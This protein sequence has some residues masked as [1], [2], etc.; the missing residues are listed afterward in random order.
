M[1]FVFMYFFLLRNKI[2]QEE[3]LDLLFLCIHRKNNHF[4]INTHLLALH[5]QQ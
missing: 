1:E 5:K 3:K 4:S 2:K